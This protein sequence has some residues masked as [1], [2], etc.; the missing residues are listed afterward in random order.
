MYIKACHS[1]LANAEDALIN[2]AD[3]A[4]YLRLAEEFGASQENNFTYLR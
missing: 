2:P 4:E 3:R 1:P